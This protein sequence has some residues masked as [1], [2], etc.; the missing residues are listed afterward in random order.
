MCLKSD[1]LSSIRSIKCAKKV[2][3]DSE[4]GT[5]AY[6]SL[7]WLSTSVFS[8]NVSFLLMYKMLVEHVA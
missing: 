3:F 5:L 2:A 7:I 1:I 6:N 4:K 8:R